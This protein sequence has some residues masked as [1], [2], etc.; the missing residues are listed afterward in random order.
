VGVKVLAVDG[1]CFYGKRAGVKV[2]WQAR[3]LAL[4][5]FVLGSH[6]M[7][8]TTP[9]REEFHI[10]SEKD[11]ERQFVLHPD[12]NDVFVR[13]GKQMIEAGRL[14]I[15]IGVWLD[16]FKEMQGFVREWCAARAGRIQACLAVGRG[17]KVLLF[18]IPTGTQFSFDL[19]D[20]LAELNRE[21][22]TSFNIGMIEVG[23]VPQAELGRFI[24]IETA[25]LVYGKSET[26]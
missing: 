21:L 22:V 1:R 19:A 2:Y 8:T 26:R 16:E 15:S 7:A 18:F 6:A 12:D 17:A 13:T 11:G 24:D 9:Q 3:A 10:D 20:E 23:Q 5:W 25:R 4:G 14:S